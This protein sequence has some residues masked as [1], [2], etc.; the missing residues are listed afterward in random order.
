L[1]P[2]HAFITG[3]DGRGVRDLGTLGGEG[4]NAF[5]INDAGQVVGD[6]DTAEGNTHAFITGPDGRGM[7]DLGTLGG[8]SSYAYNI[9]DAGQVTGWSLTADGHKHAFITAPDGRGMIDLN[10]LVDLPHGVI[11]T[12]GVGINNNGQAVAIGV[13]PEPETYALMLVGLVLVGFIGQRAKAHCY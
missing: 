13:L 3:P 4:S 11:L 8:N 2:Y 7:R 5:D 6:S 12:E 1:Y 9:N 10:S